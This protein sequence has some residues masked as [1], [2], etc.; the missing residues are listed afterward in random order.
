[1]SRQGAI[2]SGAQFLKTRIILPVSDIYD[3]TAWYERALG[4]TTSYVHGCGRRGEAE[5]F[6]N[7]AIMNRDAVEV[8][9]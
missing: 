3:T 1:M 9:P 8:H 2:M 5:D 4:F 6:A 7:Y